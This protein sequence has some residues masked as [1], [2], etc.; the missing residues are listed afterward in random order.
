MR[1]YL[2][3][4]FILF[5]SASFFSCGDSQKGEE[6]QV[7]YNEEVAHIPQKDFE[8]QK[9]N[10]QLK[11]K[12]S[13][14]R[15]ECDTI[16]LME[17]VL[18]NYPEGTYLVEVD[19]KLT[20]DIPRPAVIYYNE[21]G[22]HVFA[23]IAKS[24]QGERFIEPKNIVGY[25][26]SLIDLDSTKLGTAFFYLTLFK[27]E[28]GNFKQVWEAPIPSHGGFNNFS[29]NHWNYR[30]TKYVKVNFHYASGI[31]HIDYN[32]FLI[33]GLT[34]K[35]HLL[36]TYKG[37]NF[38]RTIANVNNDKFPDYYEHIFYDL[39][40]KVFSRDSVAFTWREK[41]SVYVNTKNSRQVRPY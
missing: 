7:N 30:D 17:Y 21:G 40:D 20:Y 37:I 39:G 14:N 31:G 1:K 16:A 23:I 33:D 35:P 15:S 27:C 34:S 26:Q 29:L 3:I 4:A 38:E 10:L 22:M 32:Y 24:K 28:D 6:P 9:Y 41:D 25:D 12:Q 19:K 5:S 8:I 11:K 18:N 36:M 13:T 2:N